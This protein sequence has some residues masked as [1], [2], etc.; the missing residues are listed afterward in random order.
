MTVDGRQLLDHSL[1]ERDFQAQVV[2]LAKLTGWRVY[3]TYDSRRSNAGFPDLVLVRPPRVIF[4]ELKRQ[5]GRV[6]VAQREWAEAL[7]ACPGVEYYLWR[8]SD[9]D[10]VEC[11][12]R[13]H[14]G[15][16]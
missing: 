8:P 11:V 9:W 10:E 12:L 6:T 15:C 2:Q 4:A 13:S 16:V 7:R 5:R 14:T 1:S 3:H